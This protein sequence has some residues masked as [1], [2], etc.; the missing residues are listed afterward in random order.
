[1][2]WRGMFYC[3]D[4]AQPGR[5]GEMTRRRE[6]AMSVWICQMVVVGNYGAVGYEGENGVRERGE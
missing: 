5:A 4:F 1:M 6:D 2:S 3:T